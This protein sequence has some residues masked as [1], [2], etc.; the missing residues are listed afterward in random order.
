MTKFRLFLAFFVILFFRLSL[1][2]PHAYTHNARDFFLDFVLL[3][4]VKCCHE[5]C[6]AY[7][8]AHLARLFDLTALR[9]SFFCNARA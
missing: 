2:S 7:A 5:E 6:P 1:C 3:R 9:R 4:V 8:V